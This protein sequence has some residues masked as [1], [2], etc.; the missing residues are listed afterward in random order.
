MDNELVD[1]GMIDGE[2]LPAPLQSLPPPLRLVG[3]RKLNDK[4]GGG[5]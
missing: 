2:G 4:G 3:R 1:A 5:L